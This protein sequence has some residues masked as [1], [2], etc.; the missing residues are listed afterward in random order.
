MPKGIPPRRIKAELY[1][2]YDLKYR[3]VPFD[4]I[5]TLDD[6]ASSH[7]STSTTTALPENARRFL[8]RQPLRPGDGGRRTLFTGIVQTIAPS[9]R[10][11][12]A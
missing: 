9:K 10:S 11:K 7:A 4:V 2:I 8:R 1:E 12:L 6:D 3:Y 5:I